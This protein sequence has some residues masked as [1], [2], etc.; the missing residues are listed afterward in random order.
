[1]DLEAKGPK[2]TWR[3]NRSGE[4]FIME[5]IDM[6]FA[7]AKWRELYDQVMVFVKAAIGSD[8]N[9]LV[10]DTNAPL[11]KVGKPFRFESFWVTE[12]ECKEVIDQ[13]WTKE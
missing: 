10:L 3:N 11:N 2:F 7:N 6:A 13:A 9:P 8:H 1:M 12:D 4:D 5:R